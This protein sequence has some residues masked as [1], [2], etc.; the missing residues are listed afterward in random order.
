MIYPD[1]QTYLGFAWYDGKGVKYYIFFV[2]PFGFSTAGFIF[3]KLM[4]VVVKKWQTLGFKVVIFLDDGLGGDQPYDKSLKASNFMRGDLLNFGF[5]IAD[6][7]CNWQPLY[8]ASWL[9][10]EWNSELQCIGC[11]KQNSR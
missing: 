4:R 10:L 3:T 8:A 5:L 1:H 9:G 7:K 11:K 2:L 6:E